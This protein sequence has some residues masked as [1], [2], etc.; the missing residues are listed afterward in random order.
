MDIQI[1]FEISKK[2]ETDLSRILLCE[3]SQLPKVLSNYSNSALREYI[4][5]FLGQKSF[6]RGTD[7]L[8]YRLFLLITMVL[9]E[10][11]DEQQVTSLFQTTL[12]ESRNLIRSVLSKYQY[13]LQPSTEN[14]LIKILKS[15]KPEPPESGPYHV[16]ISSRNL[17]DSLNKILVTIDKDGSLQLISKKS[18]SPSTYIISRGSRDELCKYLGI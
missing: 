15:A 1:N 16:L 11:P 8:E 10:I 18:G 5:Q 3:E 13:Q 17:V 4:D 9:H 12:T 2:E 7:I 14:S 6:K